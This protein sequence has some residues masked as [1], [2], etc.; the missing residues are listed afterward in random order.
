MNIL[1]RLF[2][3]RDE[4]KEKKMSEFIDSAILEMKQMNKKMEK[5]LIQL[6]TAVKIAIAIKKR[7]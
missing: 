2:S 1:D 6:D 7:K 4:E 5:K 3:V